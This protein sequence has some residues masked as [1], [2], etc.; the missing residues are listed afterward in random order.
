MRR[1]LLALAI[2]A[3]AGTAQAQVPPCIQLQLLVDDAGSGFNFFTGE[4]LG[5]DGAAEVHATNMTMAGAECRMLNTMRGTT[6]L[7]AVYRCRWSADSGTADRFRRTLYNAVDACF[8]RTR[9]GPLFRPIRLVTIEV[10]RAS[11]GTTELA[12]TRRF[13]TGR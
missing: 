1:T 12:I 9:S 11:E 5:R 4:S 8:P 2:A 10:T 13:A 3:L 6:K 7:E